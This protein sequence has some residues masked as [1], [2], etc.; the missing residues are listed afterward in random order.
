MFVFRTFSFRSRFN[1]LS[2]EQLK[3]KFQTSA[4]LS[5]HVESATLP[6]R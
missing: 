4:I 6:L 1:A 2:A 5:T 3:S